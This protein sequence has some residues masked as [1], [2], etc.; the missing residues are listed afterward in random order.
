VGGIDAMLPELA[1][2]VRRRMHNHE[3]SAAAVESELTTLL[4]ELY[5]FLQYA[6]KTHRETVKSRNQHRPGCEFSA[7]HLYE[8]SGGK[9]STTDAAATFIV[10]NGLAAMLVMQQAKQSSC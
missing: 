9:L 3:L 7:E 6:S 1:A 5:A 10:L 2:S 8:R 4:P